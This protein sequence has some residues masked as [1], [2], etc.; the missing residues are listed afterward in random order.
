M[1]T[2][3]ALICGHLRFQNYFYDT[4]R[5]R[6]TGQRTVSPWILPGNQLSRDVI[7]L[8]NIVVVVASDVDTVFLDV[9]AVKCP[10]NDIRRE[11]ATLHS[12][13]CRLPRL[14]LSSAYIDSPASSLGLLSMFRYGDHRPPITWPRRQGVST[15]IPWVKFQSDGAL[16]VV[17]LHPGG[18]VA[19]IISITW[20][21]ASCDGATTRRKVAETGRV[22]STD[23][24]SDHPFCTGVLV[25][26]VAQ[27][28]F[29]P[30]L[31]VPRCLLCG[32]F[33]YN[34]GF[35]VPCVAPRI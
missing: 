1:L 21:A 15:G 19:W 20:C 29:S 7:E 12:G 18:G 17:D 31:E 25:R 28:T 24:I 5:A 16:S 11:A 22:A 23:E 6:D 13:T 2:C 30:G 9:T 33:N 3:S 10:N 26:R 34:I 27:P 4:C 14:W 35:P 8:L 32:F